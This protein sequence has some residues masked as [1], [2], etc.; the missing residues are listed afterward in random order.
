MRFCCG[1]VAL[2]SLKFVKIGKIRLDETCILQQKSG[3]VARHV[4]V[5]LVVLILLLL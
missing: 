3:S 4:Y 5:M 2:N 1:P